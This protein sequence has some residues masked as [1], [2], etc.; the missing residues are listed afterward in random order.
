MNIL[1]VCELRSPLQ[2]QRR[3]NNNN[4]FRQ[5]FSTKIFDAR[6]STRNNFRDITAVNNDEVI[7]FL[8]FPLQETQRKKKITF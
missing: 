2:N 1:G 5:G 3:N 6:F 4:N 7:F 8:N